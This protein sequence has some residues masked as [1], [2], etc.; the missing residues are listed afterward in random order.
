MK[1][2]FAAWRSSYAKDVTETKK[3]N[4]SAQECIFCQLFKESL[5][6]PEN[7]AKSF[8][9]KQ[10]EHTFVMLNKYPYNAGHLLILPIKHV[11]N[12]SDLPKETLSE[13]MQVTAKSAEILS[14][15]LK[16]DGLNVG[17]NIGKVSGAGIPSHLHVHA[18][19]RWEGDTNFMPL[20]AETKVISFD[21]GKIYEQLRPEFENLS[22]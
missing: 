12:L 4:T 13:L 16:N 7:A 3:V 2:L 22:L 6:N 14:K 20:L 1:R 9:L 5:N 15:C 21:L 17:I 18:L 8:I 10:F 11:P 19:P